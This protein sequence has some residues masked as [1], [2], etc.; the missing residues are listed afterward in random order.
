[1]IPEQMAWL[2]RSDTADPWMRAAILSS[3]AA[4]ADRLL[5][6]LIK[7]PGDA[8]PSGMARLQTDLAVTVGAVGNPESVDLVLAAAASSTADPAAAFAV[9]AGLGDGLAR[10]KKS[11]ADILARNPA[12]AGL[13]DRAAAA[14]ADPKSA[15]ALRAQAVE[16][17]R[18]APFEKARDAI[19]PLLDPRHPAEVQLAAVRALGSFPDAALPALLLPRRAAASPAVRAEILEILLRRAAWIPA[20]LD[21]VEA[22]TIA[23]TD[24]PTGRRSTLQ[25]H[26]D[27]KIRVRAVK[28][29]AAPPAGKRTETI[30]RYQKAVADG[31]GERAKGREVF[32]KNCATCHTLAGLGTSVG[33]DLGSI[34]HRSPEE[35]VTHILD[36][37][38]EVAPDFVGYVVSLKDER[39]LT[40]IIAAEAG[41]AVTLRRAGGE[42]DVVLRDDIAAMAGTGKS[43]MPE[44]LEKAITPG[45]MGDLVA[46][47]RSPE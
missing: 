18:H 19:L 24:L 37:N 3:S 12:A 8:D 31:R 23:V 13:L 33:P 11:L 43:L 47:L 17:L 38:R 34:R 45:E 41:S 20:V 25:N 14:S 5:L 16:L 2:P 4:V 40:G 39:V 28:L 26:A 46:F 7:D 6:A 30:A 29:F 35:I 32:L 10:S 27:P 21:A 44:G 42:Q 1:M 36:P 9:V 15:P 22:G